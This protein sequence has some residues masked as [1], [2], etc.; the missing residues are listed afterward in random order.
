MPGYKTHITWSSVAGV[1]LAG[2]ARL[3]YN[4][5]L[6]QAVFGGLLCSLGGVLPDIDS[7]NSRAYRRCIATISGTSVL[8]LANRLR[9]FNLEPEAVVITCVAVYFFITYVVGGVVQK[10]TVHRG[11]CHSIPF[12]I[13][14][15]EI[16]FILSSG[17]MQ[18][19]LFKAASIFIGVLIHLMLDEFNSI[20]I[21]DNSRSSP[22]YRNSNASYDY[23]NGYET[24]YGR[25][26]S[27]YE[28]QTRKKGRF[29]IVRIKRSFGTALKFIDYNR[30]GTTIA[31]YVIAAFLAYSAMGVPDF[32]AK[33]GSVDQV[34][35]QGRMAVERVKRSYPK[36]Y[37]LS[38]IKWVA[39]NRLVLSPGQENNKKWL[40][41]QELLAIDQNK[42]ETAST[43]VNDS[44]YSETQDN[45]DQVPAEETVSLLDVIN[46]NSMNQGGKETSSNTS[47]EEKRTI[48]RINEAL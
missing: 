2:V 17:S 27:S 18:L 20:R 6:H 40:E 16:I 28:N 34:E 4:V 42:P 35:N 11:M 23:S 32:L 48:N 24:D 7:N 22:R 33:M 37:E 10:F 1:G 38:V 21:L 45:A 44:N 41:L 25:R 3:V 13:I 47:T 15:S 26:R 39:E 36:Q 14:A 46:W 9:D 8:L 19:R 30:M 12:A 29:Q 5:P 31:F 43:E